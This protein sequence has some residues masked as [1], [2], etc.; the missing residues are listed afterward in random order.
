MNRQQ[1]RRANKQNDGLQKNQSDP[2]FDAGRRAHQ[3][4]QFAEARA[5]YDQL[6]TR[7]TRLHYRGLLAFQ[8]GQTEKALTMLNEVVSLR[9]NE[10]IFHGNLANVFLNAGNNQRA[11]KAFRKAIHL[12]RNYALAHSNLA[13][14]LL[15]GGRIEEAETSVRRA[16]KLQPRNFEA[17]SNLGPILRRRGDMDGAE[18]AFRKAL[19]INPDY[20][21]ATALITDCRSISTHLSPSRCNT[22]SKMKRRL[23]NAAAKIF[24]RGIAASTSPSADMKNGFVGRLGA[25]T[26]ANSMQQVPR[27]RNL[28]HIWHAWCSRNE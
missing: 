2:R 14:S 4:G 1:R 16:L 22:L 18:V 23:G 8:Q 24:D 3:V 10:P 19:S 17:Y 28:C 26:R 9:P 25:I 15:G 21:R 11:K 20:E 7:A 12:D 27:T 6:G 13:T 5:I